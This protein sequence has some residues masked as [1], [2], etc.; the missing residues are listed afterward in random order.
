MKLSYRGV[1]YESPTA[2]R[3]LK[4]ETT[5]KYRGVTYIIQH[6]GEKLPAI[7][8]NLKYRG[9]SYRPCL[10]AMQVQS[11]FS[12]PFTNFADSDFYSEYSNGDRI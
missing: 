8:P 9:N 10:S 2:R 7:A 11:Q 6:F 1:D 4:C 3:L 5:A 12:Q